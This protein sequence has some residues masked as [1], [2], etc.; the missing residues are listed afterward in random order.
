MVAALGILSVVSVFFVLPAVQ[1]IRVESRIRDGIETLDNTLGQYISLKVE[2]YDRGW[3]R[4]HI[5]IGCAIGSDGKHPWI[6][7][8][9]VIHGPFPIVEIIKGRMSPRFFDA[10]LESHFT[11]T[12]SDTV[13]QKALK[14]ID[15]PLV[16][17]SATFST[18]GSVRMAITSPAVSSADE[19]FS[20]K[21]ASISLE[22][23]E[24]SG[25]TNI[26]VRFIGLFLHNA[27]QNLKLEADEAKWLFQASGSYASIK[28]NL[29]IERFYREHQGSVFEINKLKAGIKTDRGDHNL[30]Y[31]N[32]NA[33][34]RK[35][36][37]KVPAWGVDWEMTKFLLHNSSNNVENK[38]DIKTQARAQELVTPDIIIGPLGYSLSIRDLDAAR[39]Y[40]AASQFDSRSKIDSRSKDQSSKKE[41]GRFFNFVRSVLSKGSPRIEG[42]VNVRDRMRRGKIGIHLIIDGER[43]ASIDSFGKLTDAAI[44]NLNLRFS[45][46]LF[47]DLW[48]MGVGVYA[49][50]TESKVRGDPAKIEKEV[51]MH[52]R[53]LLQSKLLVQK[54]NNYVS[55]FS[56]NQGPITVNGLPFE[57]L[58]I[59]ADMMAREPKE[60]TVDFGKLGVRGGLQLDDIRGPIATLT[61]GLRSCVQKEIDN[62]PGHPRGVV[63]VKW[64]ITDTGRAESPVV[65]YST[66]VNQTLENCV[67]SLFSS[68]RFPAKSQTS[69]AVLVIGFAIPDIARPRRGLKFGTLHHYKSPLPTGTTYTI[70]PARVD[71]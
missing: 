15:E 62:G 30:H 27:D 61:K 45:T 71:Q 5:Q 42:L 52:I 50:V 51:E 58:R 12:I 35:M 48:R 16:N 33:S 70:G 34:I 54:E 7:P 57:F 39:F 29:D 60:I 8:I 68:L 36:K 18:N 66:V 46:G 38:Y 31:G 56:L 65:S 53:K 40:R 13:V 47:T 14:R 11:P 43:A 20:W 6:I 26:D 9:D 2:R 3:F 1:A 63:H 19:N 23:S 37:V 49:T 10:Y 28:S 24:K 21:G 41:Q 22:S 44:G 69:R 25:K 4:S 67:I 59:L 55:K 17:L 64:K 32:G